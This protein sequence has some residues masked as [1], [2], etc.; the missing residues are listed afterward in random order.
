MHGVALLF[1]SPR[2]RSSTEPL[3]ASTL[4]SCRRFVALYLHLPI[5]LVVSLPLALCV[6]Q[7]LLPLPPFFI[8]LSPLSFRLNPGQLLSHHTPPSPRE[9]EREIP[10]ARAALTLRGPCTGSRPNFLWHSHGRGGHAS[11]I[12]NDD[13][14]RRERWPCPLHSRGRTVITATKR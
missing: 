6:P 10:F 13:D 8:S 4:W 9:R 5:G 3:T 1:L 12:T 2:R 7:L 14:Y 11:R